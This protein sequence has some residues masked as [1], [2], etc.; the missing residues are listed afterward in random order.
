MTR[1]EIIELMARAMGD[2]T[3]RGNG[4]WSGTN[5][6]DIYR[7]NA[8][9]ILA[10]LK[11]SGLAIVPIEPSGGMLKDG[12]QEFAMTHQRVQSAEHCSADVY[13]AMIAAAIKE[14]EGRDSE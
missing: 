14:Q 2:D 11:S 7:S 12:A 9:E 5:D 13:K 3:N 8:R 6:K 4:G 10:R 1:S